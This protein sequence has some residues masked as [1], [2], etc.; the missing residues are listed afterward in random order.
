MGNCTAGPVWLKAQDTGLKS[1][2]AYFSDRRVC[3]VLPHLRITIA[4]RLQLEAEIAAQ[5]LA[6]AFAV[7]TS[8][9]S[10][11]GS[12]WFSSASLTQLHYN[13][14]LFLYRRQ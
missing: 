3:L 9:N 6:A 4:A 7:L 14:L 8:D 13:F 11:W 12:C 10:G 5:F 2:A 1:T